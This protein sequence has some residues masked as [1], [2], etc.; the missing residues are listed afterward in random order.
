MPFQFNF[1]DLQCRQCRGP[2]GKGRIMILPMVIVCSK[3]CA[4]K[5]RNHPMLDLYQR[6]RSANLEA[7]FRRDEINE[8]YVEKFS[9]L[10]KHSKA[11]YTET[12]MQ[13]KKRDLE[14]NTAML[15]FEV[16]HLE[17]NQQQLRRQLFTKFKNMAGQ[18]K[19]CPHCKREMVQ[20]PNS[21]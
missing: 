5:L 10:A 2:N 3:E 17:S 11:R 14:E 20:P 4:A 1:A 16:T 15:K 12:Q 13:R 7:L 8:Y 18:V 6:E 9:L 19:P 21:E